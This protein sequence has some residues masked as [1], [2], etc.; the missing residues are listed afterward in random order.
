MTFCSLSAQT[1]FHF[2]ALCV[3]ASPEQKTSH[4]PPVT[5]GNRHDQE[6]GSAHRRRHHARRQDVQRRRTSIIPI[7]PI[8][9][10]QYCAERARSGLLA[11]PRM[12]RARLRHPRGDGRAAVVRSCADRFLAARRSAPDLGTPLQQLCRC[13]AWRLLRRARSRLAHAAGAA[14]GSEAAVLRAARCGWSQHAIRCVGARRE[15]LQPKRRP[16]AAALRRR[17]G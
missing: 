5:G 10:S 13:G 9:H 12:A 11:T 8:T 2:S 16:V 7:N 15:P 1:L 4:S 14:S 6:S 17:W 3:R